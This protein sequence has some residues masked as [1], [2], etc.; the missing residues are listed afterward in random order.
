[1]KLVS[2]NASQ[3]DIEA[4]AK[5]DDP[6]VANVGGPNEWLGWGTVDQI[7]RLAVKK[8]VVPTEGVPNRT[9]DRSNIGSI[10]VAKK[11]TWY[12]PLD[13]RAFYRKLW[14]GK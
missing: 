6:E 3:A 14:G 8:P 4:I 11:N 9:F 1:V 12:G 2:Q 5:G 10:D 7:A 13:F